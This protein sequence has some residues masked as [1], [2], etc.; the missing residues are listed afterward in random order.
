MTDDDGGSTTR[1][2][3]Q[4]MNKRPQ[5]AN[6][7]LPE[8][9]PT[10]SSSNSTRH[11]HD[12]FGTDDAGVDYGPPNAFE[13]DDDDDDDDDD[14]E[15]DDDFNGSGDIDEGESYPTVT[16]ANCIDSNTPANNFNSSITIEELE[17]EVD[18]HAQTLESISTKLQNLDEEILQE[19]E[20]S[21][22]LRNDIQL[23][24]QRKLLLKKRKEKSRKL[25]E[26]LE[27]SLQK[28][29]ERLG[30]IG[31]GQDYNIEYEYD[32]YYSE[33]IEEEECDGI[34]GELPPTIDTDDGDGDAS[35]SD[36]DVNGNQGKVACD[37]HDSTS[38]QINVQDPIP[39]SSEHEIRGKITWPSSELVHRIHLAAEELPVDFPTWRT[40][41]LSNSLLRGI[42]TEKLLVDVMNVAALENLVKREEWL[43]SSEGKSR[44]STA[45]SRGGWVNEADVWGTC[46]DVYTHVD[47]RSVFA[48]FRR[49]NNSMDTDHEVDGSSTSNYSSGL[50][51]NVTICPYELGGTCADN[52]CSYQHL[53]RVDVR[54]RKAS[55]RGGGMRGVFIQY[56]NFPKLKLPRPVT[57]D[58][59]MSWLETANVSEVDVTSSSYA[60]THSMTN[61]SKRNADEGL[62]DST[63]AEGKNETQRYY[64]LEGVDQHYSKEL[65]ARSQPYQNEPPSRNDEVCSDLE[66]IALPSTISER[67]ETDNNDNNASYG[68][69]SA[70]FNGGF[71]WQRIPSFP[72]LSYDDYTGALDYM[73]LVFGF[74]RDRS[75]GNDSTI[76]SLRYIIPSIPSGCRTWN[77]IHLS[78]LI[79]LSRVLVHMGRDSLALSMMSDYCQSRPHDTFSKLVEYASG[80]IK[81]LLVGRCA[82]SIF[83]VQVRLLIISEALHVSYE[84]AVSGD[85]TSDGVQQCIEKLIDQI[86]LSNWID[87]TVETVPIPDGFET[88]LDAVRRS[89]PTSKYGYKAD[90]DEWGS[91]IN[92][93]RLMMEKHVMN[94]SQMR[95]NEQLS[96]LYQSTSLGKLLS[97][98]MGAAARGQSFVPYLHIIEPVWSTL[99]PL[100]QAM[101]GCKRWLHPDTIVIV[102]LGPLI[103]E[104]VASSMS[105][106]R[107]YA[108]SR[109]SSLELDARAFADLASLD[110]C[111]TGIFNDLNRVR[112][113]GKSRPALLELLV[114]PLFTLSATISIAQ[115]SFE[116][117]NARLENLLV[118]DRSLNDKKRPTM[119]AFSEMIWSQLVQIRMLCPPSG[120]SLKYIGTKAVEFDKP[121]LSD[122]IL[123][124]HND[125]ASKICGY[126]I[127]LWGVSLRGDTHMNMTSP[128]FNR[129]HCDEWENV[130]TQIFAVHPDNR[131]TSGCDPS[132]VELHLPNPYPELIGARCKISIF[133]ESALLLADR[134]ISLNLENCALVS[135]PSS[136]GYQIASLRVSDSIKDIQLFRL[137]FLHKTS[138]HLSCCVEAA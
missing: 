37:E 125:I 90:H 128:S 24:N 106:P 87:N 100:R 22:S 79:D 99:Q 95:V 18:L 126:G 7:F 121:S 75:H 15:D 96:I 44:A 98:L 120:D 104:W 138:H 132:T 89:I 60:G 29:I 52:Q 102:I 107:A 137:L 130:S 26:E 17:E 119:Y 84:E 40:N 68:R 110:K 50:D 62:R 77:I 72:S 92:A 1:Q 93:L 34:P 131:C 39:L 116:K 8:P 133:P 113:H 45:E 41:A 51:P 27:G 64:S 109:K 23:L 36:I 55:L 48:G 81:S 94:I 114:A 43:Q 6:S 19:E 3:Q 135:L 82:S 74:E 63:D 85:D 21:S 59:F 2:Q 101:S 16:D 47:W 80:S 127:F 30:I 115:G 65:D 83:E 86:K 33:I 9:F 53:G 25:I 31:G 67:A 123:M 78:R 10:V 28:C 32:E 124:L 136:I 12:A 5:A 88:L 76:H 134:L 58:D 69:N 11:W 91:F 105:P 111:T 129:K 38:Q 118:H 56:S 117:A 42:D 103:F 46:L 70:I 13:E 35:F 108:M 4:D 49:V 71:W 61:G 122:T 73:L 57:R 20:I 97:Q 66:F 14:D 112:T 54:K